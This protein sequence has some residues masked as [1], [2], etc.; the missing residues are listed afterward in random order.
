MLEFDST[1]GTGAIHPTITFDSGSSELLDLSTMSATALQNFDG[2]IK[3]FAPGEGIKIAGATSA[4]LD[5]SDP[6]HSHVIVSGGSGT[7][8]TLDLG[9]SYQGRTF[10]VTSN[11]VMVSATVT[12]PP[13]MTESLK[14][15]T[16]TAGDKLTSDPTLTDSGDPNAVV[17]FTIDGIQIAATTTADASGAWTL[18]PTG[19]GDGPHTIVASETN[20]GGT[21]TASL[22][23][24]LDTK[25]PTVTVSA[26]SASLKGGR[27]R[28][29]DLCFQRGGDGV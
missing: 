4:A 12:P 1:V 25:A 20:A 23:F 2:V 6:T 17:H 15:N 22:T 11:V 27:D 5:A 29:D 21:G 24:T 19:L 14:N 18:T 8:A 13:V 28:H 9:A 3:N 10:T 7:L 16:G 26:A